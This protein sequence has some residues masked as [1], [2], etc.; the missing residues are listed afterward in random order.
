[1]GHRRFDPDALSPAG[2]AAAVLAG[3]TGLSLM[4]VLLAN[5]LVAIHDFLVQTGL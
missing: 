4:F 2:L 5:S 3:A 1:M